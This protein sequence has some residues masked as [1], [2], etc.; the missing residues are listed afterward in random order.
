MCI[1]LLTFTF[2]YHTKI[3]SLEWTNYILTVA[4]TDDYSQKGILPLK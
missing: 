2:K 3:T 1:R 4:L